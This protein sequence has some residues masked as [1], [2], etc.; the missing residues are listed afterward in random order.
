MSAG[1]K[2]LEVDGVNKRFGDF[3]AVENLSFSLNKGDVFGFL[4]PNGAGKSTSIRMMLGLIK[5]DSGEI[6]V[7]GRPTNGSGRDWLQHIGCMVERPDFYPYLNGKQNLSLLAGMFPQK[8]KTD[9]I[10]QALEIT[11]LKG[12]ETKKVK[13]YSQGMKQRLGL[14]HALLHDPE[15]LIL[16]EPSNGLDPQ[17]VIDI[18][19]LIRTLSADFHKTILISSHILAEIEIIANRLLLINRGKTIVQGDVQELIENAPCT[20]AIEVENPD[21]LLDWTQKNYPH[22]IGISLQ[23]KELKIELAKKEIP[24]LAQQ[25]VASGF[26]IRAIVPVR[27][28]ESYFLS[29]T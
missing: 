13:H 8:I 22:G 27:P 16:D 2:V 1:E 4:G 10:N 21:S 25:L 20:V 6:K 19:N 12:H 7:M 24:S 5:P 15:V 28:L 23:E 26:R 17:G 29:L 3:K 18:R 9:R 14:A 11:G